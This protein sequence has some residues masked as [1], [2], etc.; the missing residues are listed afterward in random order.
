[1]K[2]I[3]VSFFNLVIAVSSRE[4]FYQT[5]LSWNSIRKKITD[6]NGATEAIAEGLAVVEEGGRKKGSAT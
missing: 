2:R 4:S 5:N 6:T 3:H 1:M